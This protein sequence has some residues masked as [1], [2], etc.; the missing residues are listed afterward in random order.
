VTTNTIT[1]LLFYSVLE[2]LFLDVLTLNHSLI[3]VRFVTD[4]GLTLI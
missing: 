4:N 2:S 3:F 1:L